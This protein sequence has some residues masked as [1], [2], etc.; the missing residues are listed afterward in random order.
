MCISFASQSLLVRVPRS[1]GAS[2]ISRLSLLHRN[3]CEN[4]SL[5]RRYV[6]L[7]VREAKAR[8][9]CVFEHKQHVEVAFQ[10]R[11]CNHT[12]KNR[13][14]SMRHRESREAVQLVK[15]FFCRRLHVDTASLRSVWQELHPGAI[16]IARGRSLSCE[17]TQESLEPGLAA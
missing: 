3:G 4:L 5:T 1:R 10:T 7:N 14:P 13:H 6:H 17:H 2:R 12:G 15:I 8:V 9:C 16:A 11:C